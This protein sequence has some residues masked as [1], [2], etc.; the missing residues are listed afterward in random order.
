MLLKHCI[1][2]FEDKVDVMVSFFDSK[3]WTDEKNYRNN[4]ITSFTS[5][6]QATL[7]AARYDSIKVHN[8]ITLK[9]GTGM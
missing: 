3:N 8:E 4:A 5:H 9:F 7:A 2:D 1:K 6:F